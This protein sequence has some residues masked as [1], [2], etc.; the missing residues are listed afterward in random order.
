MKA[1]IVLAIA[2]LAAGSANAVDYTINVPVDVSLYPPGKDL[3]LICNLCTASG[4]C[5]F[6]HEGQ[7]QSDV[8]AHQQKPVPLAGGRYSGT[9]QLVFSM[10]DGMVGKAERYRCTFSDNPGGTLSAGAV[11]P[12][13]KSVTSVEGPVQ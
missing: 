12:N 8:V 13:S 9:M 10:T 3:R 5:R 1:R 4:S 11:K 2:L 7:Q 6:D